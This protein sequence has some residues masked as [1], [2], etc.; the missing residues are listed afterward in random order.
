MSNQIQIPLIH[1]KD[2][3]LTQTQTNT[4]KVL[5]NLNNQIVALQNSVNQL[6]ILGE[7]KL[8][9]LTLA[10][11]QNEAGNTWILAN[12]QS[13]VNTDYAKLTGINVV[14][15]ITISGTNAF[16]KVNNG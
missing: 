11:F 4:N 7:I 2:G 16:I 15:N 6:T 14:P 3:N 12:G 1:S 10:Q 9:P 13:V 5:R 8:S